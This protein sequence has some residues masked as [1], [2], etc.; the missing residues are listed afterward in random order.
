[1]S[2]TTAYQ[3]ECP[4]CRGVAGLHAKADLL[5]AYIHRVLPRSCSPERLGYALTPKQRGAA[6]WALAISS[7]LRRGMAMHARCG[8][9][10]ILLGPGHTEPGI[11]GFCGT[12][13]ES[14]PSIP[15]AVRKSTD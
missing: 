14:T 10:T 12:H 3:I 15:A 13:S 6:A 1:M 11:D 4:G 7:C 5:Q 2:H 8:A 9:C